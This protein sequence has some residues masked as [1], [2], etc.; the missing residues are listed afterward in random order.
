[1]IPHKIA[2]SIFLKPHAFYAGEAVVTPFS[3]SCS[4]W[5]SGGATVGA[6]LSYRLQ[7]AD[8]ADPTLP[9][10]LL[11]YGD[12]PSTPSLPLSTGNPGNDYQRRLVVEVS[13]E[14]GSQTQVWLVVKVRGSAGG[15]DW[16]PEFACRF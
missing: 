9:L 3:V 7:T 12:Q 5:R 16:G 11:Y 6:G 2:T 15:L 14:G 4:G 8:P 1:M 10:R 13:D